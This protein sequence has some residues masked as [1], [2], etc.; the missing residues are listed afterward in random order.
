MY[1]TISRTNVDVMCA[2]CTVYHYI[3]YRCRCDVCTERLQQYLIPQDKC[4][5]IK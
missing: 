2:L 5:H 3:L 4:I 1:I